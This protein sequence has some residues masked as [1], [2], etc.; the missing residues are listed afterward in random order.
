M[1]QHFSLNFSKHSCLKQIS[2]E[3]FSTLSPVV[4]Y[5]LHAVDGAG[6]DAGETTPVQFKLEVG[7][8]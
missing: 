6:G 4:L 5:L 2:P 1:R 3:F 7:V 8:G